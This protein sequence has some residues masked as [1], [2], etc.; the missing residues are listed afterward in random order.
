MY[1]SCW[2]GNENAA[3]SP[4]RVGGAFGVCARL[5]APPVGLLVVGQ[6]DRSPGYG[7]GHLAARRVPLRFG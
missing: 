7:H 2:W 3:R 1:L 6:V 4:V 5:S